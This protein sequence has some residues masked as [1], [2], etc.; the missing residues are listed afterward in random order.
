MIFF[1]DRERVLFIGV[2]VFIFG[3]LEGRLL[4]SLFLDNQTV[5]NTELMDI[6]QRLNSVD[7]GF[8]SSFFFEMDGSLFSYNNC[9]LNVRINFNVIFRF[10]IIEENEQFVFF[11]VFF[12]ESFVL[13]VKESRKKSGYV[14]V[15]FFFL[16]S[17]REEAGFDLS[18]FFG[19]FVSD[20]KDFLIEEKLNSVCKIISNGVF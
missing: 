17:D 14:V 9:I 11:V 20:R 2:R 1:F 12:V 10:R 7:F 16:V 13:V 3:F 15:S 18:F 5:S 8:F 4:R 19:Y 6:I